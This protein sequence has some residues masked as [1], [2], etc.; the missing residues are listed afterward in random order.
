MIVSGLPERNGKRHAGEIADCALEILQGTTTF[1][2]PH[3]PKTPLQIRIGL[4]SGKY[5]NNFIINV[6]AWDPDSA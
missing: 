2:I 4:H 5:L 1:Q 3:K 6:S